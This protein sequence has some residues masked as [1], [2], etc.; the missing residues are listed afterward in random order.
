M[1]DIQYSWCAAPV[2]PGLPV[3]QA[4]GWL[5]CPRTG[6]VLIQEHEDG[7]HNLPGGTPEPGDDSLHATVAREAFEENQVRIGPETAYLG[8]QLVMIAGR[9]P[10]AQVRLAGV[11]DGFAPR[12][13]DADGG[14]LYRRLMTSLARA[15]G[16]LGWGESG[17]AQAQAAAEAARRWGLPVDAPAPD[18]YED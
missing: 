6:R 13:P 5:V 4:Y 3:T 16:V 9:E 15:P 1:T 8:Y 2:P 7:L 12:A 18:G 14:Q 11:I 10:F 17:H